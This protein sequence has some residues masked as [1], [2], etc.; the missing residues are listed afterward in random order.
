ML[1]SGQTPDRAENI[2]KIKGWQDTAEASVHVCFE[3]WRHLS[4]KS[5]RP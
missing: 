4:D 2:N 1:Y 3:K 5:L